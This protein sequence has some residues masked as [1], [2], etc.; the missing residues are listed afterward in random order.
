TNVPMGVP[1][2]WNIAVAYGGFALFWAHPQ[3]SVLDLINI[4]SPLLVGFLVVMLI[5]LPVV[6]NLVPSAVSFLLAMRYYAGNWACSVWLFRGD[7]YRRL[8]RLKKSS[9]WVDD[10]LA[11]FY[12]RPT[13]VALL[14]KVMAFRLMHLHGRLL[15]MLL[16]QAVER[17]DE[18]T[19]ADGELIAGLALG[20]NFGDG[21]LHDERLLAAIQEQCEFEPGELRC[22][23]FESQPFGRSTMRWRI[24]DAATGEM[25]AGEVTVAELR[26]RQPW[27]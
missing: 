18:Y 1:I 8:E 5:G 26:S 3:V 19:W 7:S 11:R 27:G 24:A 2:E 6:G 10:Q 14:S 17:I 9:G 20:W 22:V 13:I 4:D 15:P 21:H 25:A 16:P 23:F 12:D